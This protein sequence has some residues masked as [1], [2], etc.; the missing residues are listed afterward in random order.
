MN[1]N[2]SQEN[3][4]DIQANQISTV[5]PVEETN[6]QMEPEG[7]QQMQKS[8]VEGKKKKKKKGIGRT[9]FNIIT[10]LLFLVIIGEATIGVI[11]M[12]KIRNEEKPIW[13]MSTK[14]TETDLKTVTE[15]HLGLY[16]IIKTDTEKKSTT[17]LIP[18]FLS[19]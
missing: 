14:K 19:E 11:N 9:L 4:T 10:I 5:T 15:C 6:R 7:F 1:E 2:Q 3:V 8:Q 18:F 17:S 13:C 16:K 12:Q